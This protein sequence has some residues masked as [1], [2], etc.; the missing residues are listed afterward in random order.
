MKQPKKKV[1]EKDRPPSME[2][3]FITEEDQTNKKN[4]QSNKKRIDKKDNFPEMIDQGKMP[5]MIKAEGND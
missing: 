1:L 5:S 2:D 3:L 4:I